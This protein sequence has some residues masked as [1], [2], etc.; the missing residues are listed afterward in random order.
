MDMES[1]NGQMETF[2]RDFLKI[3]WSTEKDTRCMQMETFTKEIGKII[4]WMEKE[5]FHP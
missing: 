2:M 3:I 1:I 4:W 5:F